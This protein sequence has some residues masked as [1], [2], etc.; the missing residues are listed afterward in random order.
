V[1]LPTIAVNVRRLHDTNRSGWWVLL[2]LI[3]ILG[4]IP[5][6]VFVAQD[7]TPGRMS[8]TRGMFRPSCVKPSGDP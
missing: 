8:R 6:I 1:L 4:W 5:L 3:P 7:S 2:R